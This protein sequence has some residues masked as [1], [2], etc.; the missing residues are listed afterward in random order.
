VETITVDTVQTIDINVSISGGV[1]VTG[2]IVRQ[3]IHAA[4]APFQ[5][6]TTWAHHP[7][8]WASLTCLTASTT[9]CIPSS[10][11]CTLKV[12]KLRINRLNISIIFFIF[13]Y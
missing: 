3:L 1:K 6:I 12:K 4:E 9:F 5:S 13:F 2:G 10:E 8:G 7:S 11:A